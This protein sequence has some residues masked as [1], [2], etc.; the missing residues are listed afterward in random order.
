VGAYQM[1]DPMPSLTESFDTQLVVTSFLRGS[2]SA[3]SPSPHRC[4]PAKLSV[5]P[6]GEK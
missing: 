4:V 5:I 3:G 6:P 2:C 1:R